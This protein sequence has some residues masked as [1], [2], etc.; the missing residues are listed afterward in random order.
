MFT[1]DLTEFYWPL[2][3]IKNSHAEETF[4]SGAEDIFLEWKLGANNGCT[5]SA[6]A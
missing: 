4:I 5:I 2:V 1:K 3:R 6:S